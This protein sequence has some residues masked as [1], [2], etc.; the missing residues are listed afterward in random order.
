MI[1]LVVIFIGFFSL[2]LTF[3]LVQLFVYL[4]KYKWNKRCVSLI[5]FLQARWEL[6]FLETD[7]RITQIKAREKK[8]NQLH[9]VEEVEV[10]IKEELPPTEGTIKIS[11]DREPMVWDVRYSENKNNP[12]WKTTKLDIGE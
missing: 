8:A 7:L 12:Q 3:Q 10:Q 5:Y 9:E 11:L 4:L 2:I 6:F 1:F